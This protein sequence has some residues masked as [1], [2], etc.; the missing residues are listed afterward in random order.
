MEIMYLK[1]V[2]GMRH[3]IIKEGDY[4]IISDSKIISFNQKKKVKI[5][6]PS[7]PFSSNESSI[8]SIYNNK[9]NEEITNFFFDAIHKNYLSI[10]KK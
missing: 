3:S 10:R 1:Y 5:D 9:V 6:K 4:S 2:N 8:A 7:I